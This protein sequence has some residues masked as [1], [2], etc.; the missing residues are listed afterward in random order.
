ML[1]HFALIL[2]VPA[3]PARNS[4]R[5]HIQESYPSQSEEYRDYEGLNA[6]YA[7]NYENYEYDYHQQYQRDRQQSQ[8]QHDNQ[9]LP[10]RNKLL[11]IVLD[12]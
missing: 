3:V 4:Q 9:Q 8:M 7:Q 10:Q 5:K 1:L 2:L 11:V 6:E 12:G